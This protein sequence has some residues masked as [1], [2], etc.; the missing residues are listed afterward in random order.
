MIVMKEKNGTTSAVPVIWWM[1][2]EVTDVPMS[3]YSPS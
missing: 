1:P 2:K 3:H